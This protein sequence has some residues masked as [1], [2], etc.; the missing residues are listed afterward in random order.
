MKILLAITK[1]S[2]GG[3]GKFVVQ[4]AEGLKSNN[5]DITVLYGNEDKSL[6]LEQALRNENISIVN[7]IELQRN[8]NLLNDFRCLINAISFLNK[9]RFDIIHTHTT[10]AG[11]I[12]RLSALITGHKKII[13][14]PHGHIYDKKANLPGI[15]SYLKRIVFFLIEKIVNIAT[16]SQVVCVSEKE[17]KEILNMGYSSKKNTHLITHGINLKDEGVK[18]YSNKDVKNI[19][20]IG[21]LSTEKG[22]DIAIKA[23]KIVKEGYNDFKL[24]ILGDGNFKGQLE[25]L[26][27]EYNLQNDVVFIP[28]Q[29]DV[30]EFYENAFCVVIPSRY[31]GFSITALEAFKFTR[32]VILMEN[33]GIAKHLQNGVDALISQASPEELAKNIIKLANNSELYNNLVNNAYKKLCTE[34]SF[35]TTLKKYIELYKS[36]RN[37]C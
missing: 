31:E 20:V 29:I 14:N 35:D 8:V 5:L 10:K 15:S 27:V 16:K 6:K 25:K 30:K 33:C 37:L 24:T 19:L 12:I 17:Y 36:S 32:P 21:R 22:Q 1:L 11:V 4:L 9:N 3:A 34:F 28:S 26:T 23:L 18:K 7:K 13:Y 2:L